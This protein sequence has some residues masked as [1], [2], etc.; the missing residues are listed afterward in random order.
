VDR[1][2]KITEGVIEVALIT[3]NKELL[4]GYISGAHV[5]LFSPPAL[6]VR[7]CSQNPALTGPSGNKLL[8]WDFHLQA[9]VDRR[10]DDLIG[11]FYQLQ[12]TI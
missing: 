1:L 8:P 11:V 4:P 2:T 12:E 5:D 10:C 3:E 9:V 6:H 7:I